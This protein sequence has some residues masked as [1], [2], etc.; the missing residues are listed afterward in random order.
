[1][2]LYC[3]AARLG[4]VEAQYALGRIYAEGR[5]VARDYPVAALFFMLAVVAGPRGRAARADVS[6]RSP[7]PPFRTV[8]RTR[9]NRAD[10]FPENEP[11]GIAAT[12]F[13]VEPFVA[14]TPA[15]QK[16]LEIVNSSRPR[17]ASCRGSRIAV[18][19]AESN[20]D[21]AARSRE[22]RAGTDA[23]HP[24]DLGALQRG[25]ALTIPSRT[26]AAGSPYLRWLLAY[27]EGDVALVAA[28]YNA[29]ERAVDRYR[30]IPPVSRDARL[31]EACRAVSSGA[32]STRTTLR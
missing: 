3:R 10:A 17:T 7:R 2:R 16:A 6:S 11:A 14:V 26:S 1:M 19:R 21:P 30:G 23:A 8:C 18:I 27:F 29:G 32:T 22:K 12:R 4:H 20:F 15:Q 24:G 31:R 28:A 25:E 5:A 13:E 9:V